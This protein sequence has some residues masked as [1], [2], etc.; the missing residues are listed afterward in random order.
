MQG[1]GVARGAPRPADRVRGRASATP[2]PPAA[3]AGSVEEASVSCPA[4]APRVRWRAPVQLGRRPP[5]LAEGGAAPPARR[6]SAPSSPR[7]GAPA[8]AAP[9]LAPHRVPRRA[10]VRLFSAG[11]RQPYPSAEGR[12]RVCPRSSG[13]PRWSLVPSRGP[14]LTTREA[15]RAKRSEPC[16][17][18]LEGVVGLV[19][20]SENSQRGQVC[21]ARGQAAVPRICVRPS[22][23]QTKTLTPREQARVL[24]GKHPRRPAQAKSGRAYSPEKRE[25]PAIARLGRVRPSLVALAHKV[26]GQH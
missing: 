5:C 18:P 17:R 9:Y 12:G 11:Q 19:P 3:P 10:S 20:E 26:E 6:G 25:R 7:L 4:R 2:P 21:G 14:G 13:F 22:T 23:A 16:P 15:S 8:L 24:Q 1:C